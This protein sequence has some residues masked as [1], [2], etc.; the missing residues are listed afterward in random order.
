MIR[1]GLTGNIGSGKSLVS[2]IFNVLGIP[3][4]HS[5]PESKRFLD[6][7]E[8]KNEILKKFGPDIFFPTGDINRKALATL[9]FSDPGSLKTLNDIMHPLVIGDFRR[10][11]GSFTGIPYVI[12]EAAIIFEQGIEK[13]FDRMIHVSCPPAIA[14]KRVMERDKTDEESIRRRMV[15]QWDDLRKS[16]LADFVVINDN[17]RL[18]IP[19]VLDIHQAL[20]QITF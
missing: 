6:Q 3:V 20:L 17:T 4:Y 14:I 8:V 1:V 15:F 10:W 9:V 13:E 18:V 16:G 11:S 7:P 5:D 12:N 19:Q 2:G